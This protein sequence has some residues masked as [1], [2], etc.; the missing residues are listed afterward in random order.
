MSEIPS[1]ASSSPPH[2]RNTALLCINF[3]NDHINTTSISAIQ[4]PLSTSSTPSLVSHLNRLTSCLHYSHIYHI[5]TSHPVDHIS[6]AASHL[7]KGKKRTS[8]TT[9]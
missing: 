6:F 4:S 8:W 5:I 7:K 3:T 2:L 1:S 9:I